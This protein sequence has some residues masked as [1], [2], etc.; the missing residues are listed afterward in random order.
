[1]SGAVTHESALGLALRYRAQR[2]TT[3]DGVIVA[4]Q[5]WAHDGA[6]RKAELLLLHGFSQSHGAW[7]RQVTSPLAAEYRLVT[8]DLRGHGD[9]DKPTAAHFYRDMERWA[10]ELKAVIDQSGLQR[11]ILVAW[12]YAGR[13]VLDYLSVF[14]D[15]GISALVMTNAMAAKI[16]SHEPV[17][18]GER[19]RYLT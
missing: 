10:D 18:G 9:S 11:P 1:M 3:P 8:Y 16:V 15:S 17:L 4:V 13:V 6:P 19:T 14:G 7:L 12:S 5:D 2:V